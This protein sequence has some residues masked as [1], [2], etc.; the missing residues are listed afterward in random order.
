MPAVKAAVIRE[1]GEPEVFGFEDIRLPEPGTDELLIRH[2]AIGVN[3]ID[4]YYRSGLYPVELPAVVGDEA[5]GV[6]EAVGSGTSEFKVGDRVA[7]PAVH[8]GAYAEAAVIKQDRLIAVPE[9]L[10]DEIIAAGLLRGLT[11]EYLLRRLYPLHPGDTVVVHAA[12]GGLGLIACQ[13]AKHFGATVIGTVS[14]E[15]KAAVAR[16]NGCRH[17]FVHAAA[18]LGAEVRRITDGRMADVV[19]DSIGKDTFMNSLDCLRPRG[20]MVSFGNASGKPEPVDVMELAR[21]GSLFLTRPTLFDYT[22]DRS[23]L[24]ASAAAYFDVIE[25][26]VVTPRVGRHFRLAEVAAAHHYLRDRN[27]IGAPVL[28]P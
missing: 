5:V 11:V 4:T 19:Y 16:E 13:W 21:H 12:A 6:I 24:L 23:E 25:K 18:D 1:T 27:R 2:T 10:P 20:M 3:F 26:G 9:S 22:R 8:L 15:E 17:A 14:S 7:Y 28:I